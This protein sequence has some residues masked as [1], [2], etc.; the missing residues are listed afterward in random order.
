MQGASDPQRELL[1]VESLAGHLLPAGSVFAFLAE[2]RGRLFPAAMFEDLFPSGR[3][4]PSLAPELVASV[5]V[6]QTLHGLSDREAVE[7]V[8]FD[9]RWKAAVGLAVTDAGFHPTT[10][11]YWRARLAASKAPNRVFDAVRDVVTATRVLAGKTRR[12]L[13]S[14]VL[15]DAVARQDTVTQLIAAVRRVGRVVPGAGDLVARV[16]TGYDYSRA[17]KPDIAWDDE[18]ARQDL[19]SALVNDALA[20]LAAVTGSLEEHGGIESLEPEAAQAVALLAL[21]AGQD[22][23]PAEDSDGTDGRW[24]IARRTAADRVI[25]TVDIDA[26]HA[27]KTQHRRQDGFKAHVVVEPDTGL[28]L[29][30]ELTKASGADSSDA[31][32][33]QRLLGLAGSVDSAGAGSDRFEVLADSAYGSGSMLAT[34]DAAGHTAVIKPWPLKSLIENGFTI[35]DFT[36]HEAGAETDG[37]FGSVTCPAG[38]TRAMTVKRTAYFKAACRG[39]PLRSRCTTAS[40]GRTVTVGEHDALQRAHRARAADPDF[41]AV[42]RQHRPMVERSIAWL[43]RGNRRVPFR[44]ITKN[45]AWLHTRVAALNLRRLLAMGLQHQSGHWVLT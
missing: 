41:Q 15:D 1:D 45:D 4:R 18:Q 6:L 43:T 12:A 14:T 10:L 20:L 3:G 26:R 40:A 28:I 39:C 38:V 19:V 25:S 16:C 5:L 44:G 33:G 29:G 42:Y 24:R 37:E 34:L 17:G 30:A 36:V 22:V 27:H 9:L 11:T 8:T 2:H 21:V 23:E 31:A 13:D 32:V 35:A 7:A